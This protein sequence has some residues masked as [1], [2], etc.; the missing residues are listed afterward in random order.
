MLV[1]NIR[2]IYI[3][4]LLDALIFLLSH[5][6]LNSALIYLFCVWCEIVINIPFFVCVSLIDVAQLLKI[7]F[8]PHYSLW[9]FYYALVFFVLNYITK[10]NIFHFVFK[11]STLFFHFDIIFDILGSLYFWLNF[12]TAFEFS[13]NNL[14]FILELHRLR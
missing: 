13:Q 11:C 12:R 4:I 6:V 9:S 14:E 10:I 2:K 7:A 8:F 5:L 3:W 1:Y